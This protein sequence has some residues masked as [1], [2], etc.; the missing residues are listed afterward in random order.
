MPRPN[1]YDNM[2]KGK[3][4]KDLE[5][6]K[7]HIDARLND[8]IASKNEAQTITYRAIKAALDKAIADQ[9]GAI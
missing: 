7:P 4:L 5:A 2:M 9:K 1:K 8:F 6:L 3:S